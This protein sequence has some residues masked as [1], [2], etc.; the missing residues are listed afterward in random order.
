MLHVMEH[1]PQAVRQVRR[2]ERLVNDR[3]LIHRAMLFQDASAAAE[4]TQITL[5]RSENI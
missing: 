3:K 5:I 2:A 4:R 1:R